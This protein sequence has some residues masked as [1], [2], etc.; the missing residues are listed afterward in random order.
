MTTVA[1]ELESG[2]VDTNGAP[3]DTLAV[4]EGGKKTGEPF[5]ELTCDMGRS[6]LEQVTTV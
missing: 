3:V 6:S 1:C 5:E 2:L 4:L